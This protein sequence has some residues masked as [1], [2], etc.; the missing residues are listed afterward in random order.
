[1]ELIRKK[2]LSACRGCAYDIVCDHVWKDYVARFGESEISPIPGPRIKHPA[3]SY[4]MSRYRVP[5]VPLTP[6]VKATRTNDV[7]SSST[8]V[9]AHADAAR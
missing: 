3:H 4:V 6:C 2:R 1:V 7:S 9:I 5:G 8:K